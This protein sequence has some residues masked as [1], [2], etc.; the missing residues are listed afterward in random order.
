MNDFGKDEFGDAR[1]GD[2]RRVARLVRIADSALARPEASF[3]KMMSSDAELESTYRFL[4]N[5]QVT[6]EEVL[7]PHQHR[8]VERCLGRQELW[9]AHDTTS[10]LFGGDSQREGLGRVKGK[11]QGFD[12]QFSIALE[13]GAS[14]QMLGVLAVQR[15]NV[16]PDPKSSRK[17][18]PLVAPGELDPWKSG[19]NTTVQLLGGTVRKV[20]HLMDRAAD[21]FSIFAFLKE[22][23]QDFVIRIQHNRRLSDEE[24]LFERLD[25]LRKQPATL[26]RDVPISRRGR[27]RVNIVKKAHPSRDSRVAR[28]EIRACSV[29]MPRPEHARRSCKQESLS[30]NIVEVCERDTPEGS[31]PV[32]WKL[33]TS[34]SIDTP[35]A[36]AH[37]VDA[38]RARW[39]IEEYFKALKSGCKVQERQLDS[40]DALAMMLAIMAPVAWRLL[41]LRTLARTEA[42]LPAQEVL[43]PV[44]LKLLTQKAR[45]PM[46]LNPTVADALFAVARLGGFLKHNK[47]PGWAVIAR[48][49]H[50]LLL[51]EAGWNS[52][53]SEMGCE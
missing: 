51:L 16:L 9:V 14:R 33:V 19:V 22:K 34:L 32:N 52:A 20:V 43:T 4:N 35:E 24:K 44:Q 13:S 50:D 27:N 8:T 45:E 48:G 49:F 26:K 10:L 40:Y 28:L 21:G 36:L 7:A 5:T 31:T 29:D 37:V 25:R 47:T 1:L 6:P 39:T 46:P 18:R 41:Q 11:K 38:Y 12:A 23:N 53:L 17:R 15:L 30:L 42:D 2:G 3:P